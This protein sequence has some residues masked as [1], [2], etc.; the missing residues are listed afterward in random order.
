MF[1][2]NILPQWEDTSEK[3]R[4][5][6]ASALGAAQSNVS[7]ALRWIQAQLWMQSM[8]AAIIREGEEGTLPI[9]IRKVVWDKTI[10]S[11]KKFQSL[12]YLVKF[13][14]LPGAWLCQFMS[15]TGLKV[16]TAIRVSR[17]VVV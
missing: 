13:H 3:D 8:T 10:D 9:E 6:I 7:L 14:L 17:I 2:S 11:E 12:W 1:F 16:Q 5:L 4:Q 15:T